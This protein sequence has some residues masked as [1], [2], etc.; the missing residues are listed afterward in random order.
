[1]VKKEVWSCTEQLMINKT[2]LEE[3]KVN[4][5]SL[6]TMWLD[7]QKAFDSVPH[8]WLIKSLEL[9]KIPTKII[10]ALKELIKKWATNIHL[11]GNEQL[12]EAKSI[13]YLRDIF[14]G[15]SLSVF[16]FILRVNPLSFLLN[17]LQRYQQRS[18]RPKHYRLILR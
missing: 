6:I 14:Q 7:Y 13:H 2:I 1:M 12:I 8:E 3:V 18:S 9:A 15:D 10:N 4:R 17:K 5:R 16:L 11:Q